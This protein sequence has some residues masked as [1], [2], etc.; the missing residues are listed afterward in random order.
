MVGS[1][2]ESIMICPLS[3]T[4][5]K[6]RRSV[7]FNF[8]HDVVTF[9]DCLIYDMAWSSDNS[10]YV[11]TTHINTLQRSI[12][13]VQPTGGSS[14]ALDLHEVNTTVTRICCCTPFTIF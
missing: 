4:L 14:L 11:Y 2:F 1:L 12:M 8:T 6:D 9:P 13:Q 5:D 3:Y 7:E 10:L